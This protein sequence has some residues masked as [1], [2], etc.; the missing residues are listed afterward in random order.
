MSNETYEGWTNRETWL[1]KLWMDNDE[2]CHDFWY[3]QT[4]AF[5]EGATSN[6]AVELADASYCLAKAL[7]A[8][9][10]DDD[11][12]MLGSVSGT[13]YADLIATALARVNWREIATSMVEDAVEAN[14]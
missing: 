1:V 5:L 6:D 11:A 14:A 8:H 4:E 13:V 2:S 12:V 7:Q 10:N 3:E 9:H